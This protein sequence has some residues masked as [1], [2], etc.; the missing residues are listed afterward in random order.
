MHSLALGPSTPPPA[1]GTHHPHPWG[2]EQHGQAQEQGLARAALISWCQLVSS[3]VLC[4]GRR[5]SERASEGGRKRPSS[6]LGLMCNF[7]ES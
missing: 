1:G 3:L 4:Q 7:A 5:A 6:A 2:P